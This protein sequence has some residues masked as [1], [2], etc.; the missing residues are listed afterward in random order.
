MPIEYLRTLKHDELPYPETDTTNIDKLRILRAAG[1]VEVE[2]PDVDAQRPVARII[3]VTGLGC[4]TLRV[5]AV[6]PRS[7]RARPFSRA[8]SALM[9]TE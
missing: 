8:L 6:P 2:L 7:R 1:M 5:D 4:A 3:A 9:V